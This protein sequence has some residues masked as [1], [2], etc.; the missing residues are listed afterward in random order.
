MSI[1]R[2]D[3]KKIP[4]WSFGRG[5]EDVNGRALNVRTR[6]RWLQ[7]HCWCQWFCIRDAAG[8]IDQL[9]HFCHPC[10][11]IYQFI[12]TRGKRGYGNDIRHID[13]RSA[14]AEGPPSESAIISFIPFL[15]C[16]SFPVIRN[17]IST[18]VFFENYLLLSFLW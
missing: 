6:G 9:V 3:R 8:Y 11:A 17:S 15:V 12:N 10:L 7:V 2:L 1:Y 13:S 5:R 14:P 4:K 18:L 16:L